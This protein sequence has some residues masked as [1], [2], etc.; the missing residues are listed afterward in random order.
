MNNNRSALTYAKAIQ[1]LIHGFNLLLFFLSSEKP[2]RELK[3]TSTRLADICNA[4]KLTPT[5]ALYLAARV[6][7]SSCDLLLCRFFKQ[8]SNINLSSRL[9]SKGLSVFKAVNQLFI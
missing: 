5:E 2:R 9:I 4:I 1:R 3:Y 8:A 7:G 6:N